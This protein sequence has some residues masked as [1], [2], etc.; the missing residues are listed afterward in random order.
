MN[1][2]K[3]SFKTLSPVALLLHHVSHQSNVSRTIWLLNQWWFTPSSSSLFYGS[4]RVTHCCNY[5]FFVLR[6]CIDAESF[7]STL[8]CICRIEK[9]QHLWSQ[10]THSASCS[11]TLWT[12][13][14]VDLTTDARLKALLH[15]FP[16]KRPNSSPFPFTFLLHSSSL[17]G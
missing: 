11:M 6:H 17:N 13:Y 10:R 14:T 5:N 3:S 1:V 15:R 9:S 8:I 2:L 16:L 12:F 4:W 7:T